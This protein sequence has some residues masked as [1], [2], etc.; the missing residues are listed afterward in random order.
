MGEVRERRGITLYTENRRGV[1]PPRGIALDSWLSLPPES[2]LAWEKPALREWPAILI[3]GAAVCTVHS[4]A[5]DEHKVYEAM[6]TG[7]DMSFYP[8][9]HHDT[10]RRWGTNQTMNG[11]GG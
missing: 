8:S 2:G 9:N 6:T 10:R 11:E 1:G 5:Y 7:G 4:R 3:S